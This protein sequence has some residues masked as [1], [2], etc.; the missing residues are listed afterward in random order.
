[1]ISTLTLLSFLDANSHRS[2]KPMKE[3]IRH[4]N[5]RMN[6]PGVKAAPAVPGQ[7]HASAQRT[8][9]RK[10][11]GFVGKTIAKIELSCSG[12]AKDR[13][14]DSNPR[15]KSKIPAP[16]PAPTRP[17][18][19][20]GDSLDHPFIND[21]PTVVIRI[22]STPPPQAPTERVFRDRDEKLTKA[23]IAN[24]PSAPTKR[25]FEGR[26][27]ALVAATRDGKLI[28]DTKN[29]T[30]TAPRAP[31]I[32]RAP[33]A[34][35][36]RQATKDLATARQAPQAT[37]DLSSL[38][39]SLPYRRMHYLR[40]LGEGG[41]GYA[42]LF[43]LHNPRT[44]LVVKTFKETPQ[45]VR[46]RGSEHAKPL[47]AHI[48][49]DILGPHPRILKLYDYIHNARATMMFYEFCELN[50]LQEVIENYWKHGMRV[51]EGFIWHVFLQM[52]EALAYIHTGISTI[53]SVASINTNKNFKPITHRDIKPENIFLRNPS[54]SSAKMQKTETASAEGNGDGNGYPDLA[55]AD[56]G[57][58]THLQG[59]SNPVGTLQFQGPEVPAQTREG[60]LWALGSV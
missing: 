23:I 20:P 28:A 31:Q 18:R 5:P 22:P 8:K 42:D 2:R 21:I 37:Q 40:R 53:P 50:T 47:E 35:R 12:K 48:L 60:D 29:G 14:R 4:Q 56:W 55:L 25:K 34:P 44:L 17:K 10:E 46:L 43:R 24:P 16:A 19:C 13:P 7:M 27:G 15:G 6:R 30:A 9:L 41:E 33:Q 49:N 58:A 26:D 11:D 51:P 39:P 59:N 52:A 57:L 32:A 1:M 54:P 36:A 3:M 45:L 38:R